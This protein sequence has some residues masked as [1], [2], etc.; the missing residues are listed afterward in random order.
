MQADP[1][2][3]CTTSVTTDGLP[4][5]GQEVLLAIVAISGKKGV[6]NALLAGSLGERRFIQFA[7]KLTF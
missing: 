7:L 3:R 5:R 6:Q 1:D 2:F 4:A